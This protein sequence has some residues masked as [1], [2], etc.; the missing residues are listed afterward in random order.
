M[1]D[2]LN[3]KLLETLP[4]YNSFIDVPKIKKLTKMQVLKQLPFYDELKIT[5]INNA[6]SGYTKTYKID[7]VD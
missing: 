7:I 1:K 6:F 4:F 3:K 5:K 2:D